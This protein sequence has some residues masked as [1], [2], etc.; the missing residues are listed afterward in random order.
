MCPTVVR[1]KKAQTCLMAAR[2]NFVSILFFRRK[3]LSRLRVFVVKLKTCR[4]QE[5]AKIVVIRGRLSNP[6]NPSSK[7][8]I[9][10]NLVELKK[11]VFLF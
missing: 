3:N 5:F 7:K 4:S 11:L 1:N 6:G 2:E 8:Y 9:Q 10:K